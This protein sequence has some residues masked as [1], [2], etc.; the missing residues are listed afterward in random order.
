MSKLRVKPIDVTAPGS[1][2]ARSQILRALQDIRSGEI[3]YVAGQLLLDELLLPRLETTDGSD[4]EEAIAELSASDADQMMTQLLSAE[5]P[6]QS[7]E[8]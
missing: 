1:F 8:S 7:A 2:K 5:V 3:D 6:T 4:L